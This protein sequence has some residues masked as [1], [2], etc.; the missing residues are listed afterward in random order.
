MAKATITSNVKLMLKKAIL[1]IYLLGYI[2][3]KNVN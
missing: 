3:I 2:Q 1:F